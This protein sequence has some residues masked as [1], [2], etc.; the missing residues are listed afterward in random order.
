MTV[1][2]LITSGRGPAECRIAVAKTLR[3]MAREASELDL[4][5][6]IVEGENPDGH[7]P[8]SAI[9]IASGAEAGLFARRWVGRVQW[10]AQSPVRPLHKRKN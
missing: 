1:R 8:L 10:I 2:L 7:G 5:F 4:D 6:D 9:V 3:V